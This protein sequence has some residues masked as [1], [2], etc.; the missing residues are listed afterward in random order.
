M[1]MWRAGVSDKVGWLHHMGA[2]AKCFW[3]M[4]WALHFIPQRS[5]SHAHTRH[6]HTR[7]IHTF[8]STAIIIHSYFV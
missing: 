7:G 2:Q 5:S 8:S 6:A 4:R 3:N 1:Q